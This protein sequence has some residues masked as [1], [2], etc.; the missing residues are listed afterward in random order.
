M[1]EFLSDLWFLNERAKG[2]LAN[3]DHGHADI[4]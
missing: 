3:S 1:N 4:A 2:N